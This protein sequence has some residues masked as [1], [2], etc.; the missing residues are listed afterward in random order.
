MDKHCQPS[1]DTCIGNILSAQHG[2]VTPETLYRDIAGYHSTGN[3][4]VI[5]MDP[6]NQQIWATW[7]EYNSPINAY[8]RS[9]IHVD[10]S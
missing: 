1:G 4:Q 7:S 6:L 3:A 8:E 10:L 2:K 5:V 9:P